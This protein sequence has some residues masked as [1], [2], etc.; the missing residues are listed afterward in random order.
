MNEAAAVD[1]KGAAATDWRMRF[2]NP[3][4][5]TRYRAEHVRE[6]TLRV[7]LLLLAS[8]M[9]VAQ[10]GLRQL[11]ISLPHDPDF[12]FFSLSVRFGGIIPVWLLMGLSPSLPGHERRAEWV[13]ALGTVLVV[14]AL[15]LLKWYALV[16]SQLRV[17]AGSVLFDVVAIMSISVFAMPMLLRHV[18]LV[19]IA[20]GG[21]VIALFHS[22]PLKWGDEV[23]ILQSA[24]VGV[25]VVIAGVAW[26]RE[27]R[28][29][30]D[31]A[32]REEVASLNRE[33]AR[34]NAEKNEFM[35]TAAH[36]L[37]APLG[38]ARGLAGQ[39]RMGK[40][41]DEAKRERALGA[42]DD[43]LGRMQELVS[44]YLG[45]H[46][47]ES[48]SLPLRVERVDLRR[49]IQDVAE[50]HGLMARAKRQALS[51][52]AGAA[53]WAQADTMLLGQV[54]DN[55]VSNALKFSAPG[56]PVRLA[57]AE[58]PDLGRVRIE[59][60]DAGPGIPAEEQER[61]FHKHSR[62]SARPTGGES[63]HGLGL[64][65]TKRVAEAMD[66]EVGCDSEAGQGATF[67]VSL[68]VAS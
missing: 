41:A 42:V 53:V 37:R 47:I 64:A 2:A 18:L 29:R 28:D 68:P 44:N 24:L 62:T 15:G 67:W 54:L 43:L 33:L 34:L 25:S 57:L 26:H 35:A 11:Q 39:V 8:I 20:G 27:T 32:R 9:V 52:A 22:V 50:R 30:R 13:Y 58:A 38:A 12:A 59:V 48:G 61:L 51:V 4:W 56:S 45:A 60:I 31:F 5:E 17:A 65:V 55:F 1:A 14:W 49:A 19:L 16:Y 6:G 10:L 40:F 7:R 36:D 23:S 63:S 21:G 66:G 46:A 3:D